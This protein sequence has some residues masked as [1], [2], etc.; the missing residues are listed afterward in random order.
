MMGHNNFILT[1]GLAGK[2]LY[3]D[4]YF[5]THKLENSDLTWKNSHTF[6]LIRCSIRIGSLHGVCEQSG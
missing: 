4:C 5:Q 1:D 3:I 6:G 2:F